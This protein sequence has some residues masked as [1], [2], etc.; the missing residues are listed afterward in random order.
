MDFLNAGSHGI[1]TNTYQASIDGFMEYLNLTNDESIELIKTAVKLAHTAREKYLLEQ[2]EEYPYI[3]ESGNNNT[4]L[5]N[6]I[7]S[8][9][10]I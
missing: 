9:F 2:G 3:L 5:I 10:I 7:I 6:K 4:Y 8:F 1:L